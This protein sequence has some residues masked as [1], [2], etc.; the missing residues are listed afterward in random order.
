M[1]EQY[2]IATIVVHY[3]EPEYCMSIVNDLMK[4]TNVQNKIIV[5]DNFSEDQVYTLLINSLDT[6]VIDIVRQN[7]NTGFG[8]GV[9]FGVNFATKYHPKY[10]HVI[11]TDTKIINYNYLSVL[12]DVLNSDINIS[13]AAPAVLKENGDVQNTIMSFPSIKS[14]FI[15]KKY[16]NNQSFVNE[17]NENKTVDVLNGV[18]FLTRTNDFLLVKGFDEN[19]FMYVEE[20]DYAFKIRK[21]GKKSVFVSTQSIVHFGA[22]N[23][24]EDLI[25]WKYFYTRRNLILFMR[26]HSSVFTSFIVGILFIVSLLFKRF[27]KGFKVK[28]NAFNACLVGFIFTKKVLLK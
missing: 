20:H 5:V 28:N 3:N 6:S 8:G 21:I 24:H 13:V 9:N 23:F 26:K 18:C 11:N 27:V 1:Q 12:E 4:L 14:I 7:K 16:Y 15:F 25:D 2:K 19:Y 17:K 10:I 22:D